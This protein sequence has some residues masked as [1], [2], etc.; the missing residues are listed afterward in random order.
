[1]RA[2]P[3][4][5]DFRSAGIPLPRALVWPHDRVPRRGALGT[6]V[7]HLQQPP[8][9]FTIEQRSRAWRRNQ[10]SGK[11]GDVQFH[12]QPGH[13][14]GHGPRQRGEVLHDL[15][16]LREERDIGR[17]FTNR[18]PIRRIHD[19]RRG[20]CEQIQDRPN[21]NREGTRYAAVPER[22]GKRVKVSELQDG[23]HVRDHAAVRVHVPVDDDGRKNSGDGRRR[24]QEPVCTVEPS[25]C[26]IE[27]PFEIPEPADPEVHVAGRDDELARVSKFAT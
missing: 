9:P 5:L 17:A 10:L 21:T 2:Q 25:C 12:A 19:D 23:R 14:G 24:A 16:L 8:H 18:A 11:G 1:M 7:S 15:R 22:G 3:E 4:S 27:L 6:L 20:V 13:A 26:R